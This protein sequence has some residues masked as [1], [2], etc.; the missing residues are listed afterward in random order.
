MAVAGF[1]AGAAER[2]ILQHRDIVLDHRRL[3]DYHASTMVDHDAAA[4]ACGRMDVDVEDFR[5]PALQ[6][7]GHGLTVLVPQPVG[8]RSEERRVGNA[9]VSPCRSRWSPYH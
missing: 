5:G 8:A 4:E 3:A 2:D 7:E 9:C 1:L 6:Q